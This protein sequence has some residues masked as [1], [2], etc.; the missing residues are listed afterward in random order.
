MGQFSFL[1]LKGIIFTNYFKITG[2]QK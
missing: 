1:I 2:K